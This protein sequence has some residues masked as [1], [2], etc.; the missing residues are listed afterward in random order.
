ML[1]ATI[2]N[3]ANGILFSLILFC[4]NKNNLKLKNNK[5]IVVNFLF[6]TLSFALVCFLPFTLLI[7]K[8]TLIFI[9]LF[10][11]NYLINNNSSNIAYAKST[12]IY[13][14]LIISYCLSLIITFTLCRKAYIIDYLSTNILMLSFKA[15]LIISI[16]TIYILNV[17]K[18]D[19]INNLEFK[20]DKLSIIT[21]LI[22]QISIVPIQFVLANDTSEI[23]SLKL[24]ILYLLIISVYSTST[25]FVNSKL[26]KCKQI[27]EKLEIDNKSMS[28]LI[29]GVRT[30][31]HD[32]G[33]IFQTI[34]GYLCSKDYDRLNTYVDSIMKE[35]GILNNISAL[36]TSTFDEPGIYGIVGSKQF[37]ANSKGLLFDLDVTVKVSEINFYT[38]KLCRI[39]G[40]ILDNAIEASS[41]S[42]EKYIKLEIHYSQIK[43]AHI[44]R[45]YN[46]FNNS[47]TIDLNKIYEKGYS[48]KE[49]KSGIGLWEVKRIINLSKN[50]QIFATIENEFFVQ[51][52][53]IEK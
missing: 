13:L 39:L 53:I 25:T 36:N 32:Y 3:I 38:P 18:K 19:F 49:V 44:I 1:I 9:L 7:L 35:F 26:C 43:N 6:F 51:N 34:N 23:T 14:I 12:L 42:K 37:Y 21:L 46:T 40:I 48:S 27:N 16:I 33:N 31:K 41:K 30:I 10:L 2:N 15:L 5:Y 47:E 20:C 22:L 29:D 45:V 11:S 17:K 4:F 50:S 52:I 24:M 8:T 28:N